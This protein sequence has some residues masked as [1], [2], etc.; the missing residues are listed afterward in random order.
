MITSPS[1]PARRSLIVP[2]A[3]VCAVLVAGGVGLSLNTD[4]SPGAGWVRVGPVEDVRPRASCRFPTSPPTS[5]WTPPRTQS[6]CLPG[7]RT[8]ASES[9]IARPRCG[10]RTKRTE[11]SSTASGN[12][13]LGPAPR[14][15][16][17]LETLVRDGV[18]WVNPNEI[19][20]GPPR[21]SRG[22]YEPPAAVL[23]GTRLTVDR[24]RLKSRPKWQRPAYRSHG[25]ADGRT[26]VIV[27]QQQ[28][29]RC[30]RRAGIR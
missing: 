4:D 2:I 19:E 22:A 15:L 1:S 25:I 23:D 28:H 27:R 14:G 21:G 11:R 12:Y 18:V 16:D 17:R 8:L 6:R 29:R 10:S 26:V 13:I 7:A 20:L 5:S 3:I 24:H 9:S 30:F